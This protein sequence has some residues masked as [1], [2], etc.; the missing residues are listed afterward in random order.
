MA[1]STL[2]GIIDLATHPPIGLLNPFLDY[3]GP[4]TG[5]HTLTQYSETPGPVFT[6]RNVDYSYGVLVQLNGA[7]PPEWGYQ[8]GWV[9][10]DGQYDESAYSPPLGQ[11]VVQHQFPGGIYVT[12][13]R[14]WIVT[15]PFVLMWQVALPARI[16][17]RT[18]PGVSLDLM[19]LH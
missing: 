2:T 3:F 19:Y 15:F 17:L 13:Q 12:T 6:I 11:L 14:E 8:L 16:G 18:A 9:S 10:D 4:Y 7:I 5:N 1:V